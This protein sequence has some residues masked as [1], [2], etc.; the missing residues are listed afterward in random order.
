MGFWKNL[1]KA[2]TYPVVHPHRTFKNT[3]YVAK[4]GAVAVPAAYIGWEKLR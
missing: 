3:V 4:V 1:A 2:A